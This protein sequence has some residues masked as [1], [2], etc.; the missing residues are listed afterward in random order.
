MGHVAHRPFGIDLEDGPIVVAGI[1]RV[2]EQSM[3]HVGLAV[4]LGGEN[5]VEKS[6]ALV[7]VAI[8]ID[9]DIAEAATTSSLS[10]ARPG[11]FRTL[12][13]AG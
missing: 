7:V 5:P 9:L 12:C 2:L 13:A 3:P 8:G 11:W 6:V 4:G 1:A 10:M